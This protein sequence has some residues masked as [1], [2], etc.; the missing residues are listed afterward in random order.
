MV[1]YAPNRTVES[2]R[3]PD[4][5]AVQVVA[6]EE[7]TPEA[8]TLWLAKPGTRRAPAPYLPGQFITLFLPT[9]DGG[10]ISRSYSLCGDGRSDQ[11]WE[12]TVK[13]QRGG[14]IS[15]Y[16]CDQ[17]APG[18]VLQASAPSGS[19]T[20]PRSPRRDVPLVLVATGSGITPMVSLLRALARVAPSARPNVQLHY[21]YH[22]A[23]DAIYGRELAALDSQREWLR[24]WHYV[25]TDGHRLTSAQVFAAAGGTASSAQ[26]YICGHVA[27][28]EELEALLLQRGVPPVR[29][30]KETFAS[31]RIA[32]R[33]R[34]AAGPGA[35][36]RLA[37]T[38]SV[39]QARPGETLL[40]TLER[41]GYATFYS[42]R[43][44]ACGTCRLKLLAGKV[45][46]GDG[47]GLA[48]AERASGYV[49]SCVAEPVG[50]VLVAG[51]ASSARGKAAVS[52]RATRPRQRSRTA[53]R[54]ALLAASLALFV[55]AGHLVL[56]TASA[57]TTSGSNT[58]GTS[59]QQSSSS[60][61]SASG[62]T[63]T[64]SSSSGSSS[65][66]SG[67]SSV[68][69]GSSQP[70]ATATTSGVS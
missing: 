9:A 7:A 26:W 44:G 32:E 11:L 46:H 49:L 52:A 57:Q 63:G 37:E 16:L 28:K 8:V 64:T 43:A 23:A 31:P 55:G 18:M 17:I 60:T 12:I 13:R 5:L 45:R 66:T 19:F 51:V 1:A 42:C 10:T 29:I 24:Q 4:A 59:T 33:P 15:P 53:M 6:R 65:T 70:A 39:L 58:S 25:S 61:S 62:S 27:L 48:P 22:R 68:T 2:V 69:T 54:G 34:A 3:R 30:H 41:C 20:L 56:Q 35:W 40:E 38:G 14:L 50:D 21:A 36:V 47:D 67:S